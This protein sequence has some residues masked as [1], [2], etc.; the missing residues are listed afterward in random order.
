MFACLSLRNQTKKNDLISWVGK[1]FNHDL[2][3]GHLEKRDWRIHS[4]IKKSDESELVV[5]VGL[6]DVKF[7]EFL[8]RWDSTLSC[9]WF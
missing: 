6:S 1:E 3:V 4:K 7:C 5:V 8:M 2:V 9:L